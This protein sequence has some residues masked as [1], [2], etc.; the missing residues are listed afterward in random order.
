MGVVF[1]ESFSARKQWA[2]EEQTFAA[3]VA[4]IAALVIQSKVRAELERRTLQAERL[5]SL[6]ILAGGVAHDFNNILTVILGHAEILQ[7][8]LSENPDAMESVNSILKAVGNAKDLASHMLN[9]SGR[10]TF[11]KSVINLTAVV[12]DFCSGGG[13][14]FF[15]DGIL[16]IDKIER[17][18]P[19]KLEPG[20][21]HQV[22]LNL[23]INA[24]MLE[25]VIFHS[26]Q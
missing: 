11:L 23:V 26:R 12:Q 9:Y 17:R 3:S 22:L 4:D 20:K 24:V 10:G 7:S 15:S 1:N 16:R 14:E 19:V 25:H 2:I 6:G 21:I 13:S 5:E 18:L 8:M